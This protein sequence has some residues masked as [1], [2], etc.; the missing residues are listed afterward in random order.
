MDEFRF[1][2]GSYSVSTRELIEKLDELALYFDNLYLVTMKSPKGTLL[3]VPTTLKDAFLKDNKRFTAE[4]VS[5]NRVANTL[6]GLL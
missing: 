1:A 5:T 3:Y 2:E 6:P 4:M